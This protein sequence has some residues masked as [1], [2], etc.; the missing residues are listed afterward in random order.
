MSE[1]VTYEDI[2][3]RDG[4]LVYTN[5]GV[6]MLPLLREG[7]DLMEIRKKGEERCRR[8][9]TILFKRENGQYILHRILEVRANGYWVV[10]DNCVSGE[11]VREEQILGVLTAVVR[12]GKRIPVTDEGYLRYVHLWCDPPE[13]RFAILRGRNALRS[14]AAKIYHKIIQK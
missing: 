11:T 3:E 6:S 2:L 10:G 9:D 1:T 7:R 13:R 8:L 4:V 5:R 12:N 14:R